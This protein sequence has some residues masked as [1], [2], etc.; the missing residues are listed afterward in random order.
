MD[1]PPPLGHELGRRP[2]GR[3]VRGPDPGGVI[4][5][6]EG[7]TVELPESG[8]SMGAPPARCQHPHATG[9]LLAARLTWASARPRV[10]V[11]KRRVL[12]LPAVA[13]LLLV[14]FAPSVPAFAAEGEMRWGL[15]VT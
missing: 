6:L 15:H 4:A 1:V 7:W 10:L 9:R 3:V 5:S 2:L 11:M 14:G 8:G 13:A 12:F